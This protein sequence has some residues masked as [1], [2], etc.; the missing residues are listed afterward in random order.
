M[1]VCT[2]HLD[3]LPEVE[4]ISI[5]SSGLWQLVQRKIK[6]ETNREWNCDHER[7]F[8]SR[9]SL[10]PWSRVIFFYFFMT[11]FRVF[12]ARS[13]AVVSLRVLLL[14][15]Y[16]CC[17]WSCSHHATSRSIMSDQRCARV[18]FRNLRSSVGTKRSRYCMILHMMPTWSNSASVLYEDFGCFNLFFGGG[19]GGGGAGKGFFFFNV[20][21]WPET[22]LYTI[23]SLFLFYFIFSMVIAPALFGLNMR[24]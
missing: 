16:R 21:H 1:L 6:A 17:D 11:T 18:A 14:M 10:S 12:F 7:V 5:D 3:R 8:V 19:G 13:L 23:P 15:K 24:I 22:C 20:C 4:E 9:I 2:F